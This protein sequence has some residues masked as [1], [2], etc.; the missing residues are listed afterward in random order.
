MDLRKME[1]ILV[2]L[3]NL[4]KLQAK[5]LLNNEIMY[6]FEELLDDLDCE[7]SKD[8]YCEKNVDAKYNELNDDDE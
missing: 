4:I 5:S 3:Y 8:T 2:A 6:D 7:L 1:I